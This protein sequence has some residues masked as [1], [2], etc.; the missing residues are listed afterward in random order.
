MTIWRGPLT[1]SEGNSPER[2]EKHKNTTISKLNVILS[3]Q[4]IWKPSL[5]FTKVVSIF[6]W[7]MFKDKLDKKA[8][9]HLCTTLSARVSMT[10]IRGR[11][12]KICIVRRVNPLEKSSYTL[13]TGPTFKLDKPSFTKHINWMRSHLHLRRRLEKESQNVRNPFSVNRTKCTFL[14]QNSYHRLLLSFQ[15]GGRHEWPSKEGEH[16]SDTLWWNIPLLQSRIH[17]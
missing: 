2:V 5:L 12:R 15:V 4:Q 16:V 1:W 13:Y 14:S 3:G 10:H 6:L 9:R 8:N 7:F 17:V 11:T